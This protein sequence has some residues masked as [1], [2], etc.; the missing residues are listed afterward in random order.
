MLKQNTFRLL[1]SNK[2]QLAINR[3]K[4]FYSYFFIF[5]SKHKLIIFKNQSKT[6]FSNNLTF[7][8]II[9][10]LMIASGSMFPLFC[11][12]ITQQILEKRSKN[13]LEERILRIF[14]ATRLMLDNKL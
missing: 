14:H 11:V 13:A 9:D 6:I 4:Y 10:L 12:Q 5:F 7:T 2:K 8:L 3:K 1:K